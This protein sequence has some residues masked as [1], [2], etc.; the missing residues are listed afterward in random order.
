MKTRYT[1]GGTTE[2]NEVGL[3]FWSRETMKHQDDDIIVTVTEQTARRPNLICHRVYQRDGLV[4]LLLQYNNIIDPIT[5]LV[6]GIKLRL[7]NPIR[8]L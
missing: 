1:H 6:P 4:W 8:V 3:G 5:E 2:S 7:P